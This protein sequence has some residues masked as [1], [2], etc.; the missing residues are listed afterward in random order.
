M[1]LRFGQ[2]IE[3]RPAPA[4]GLAAALERELGCA[5]LAR[6]YAARGV[7]AHEID[8]SPKRLLVVA[9]YDADGATGCALAVRGLRALGA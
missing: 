9:D 2:P 7:A 4:P 6:L 1:T 8:Y 5:V 3:R